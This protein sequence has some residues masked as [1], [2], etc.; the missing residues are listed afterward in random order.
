MTLSTLSVVKQIPQK[1]RHRDNI[2]RSTS[3]NSSQAQEFSVP[4]VIVNSQSPN[5]Q[6]SKQGLLSECNT[7][8]LIVKLGVQNTQFRQRFWNILILIWNINLTNSGLKIPKTFVFRQKCSQ[9]AKFYWCQKMS[10]SSSR[11]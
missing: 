3:N 5:A 2:S 10:P 6:S 1:I 8:L 11:R 7:L 9:V 4:D